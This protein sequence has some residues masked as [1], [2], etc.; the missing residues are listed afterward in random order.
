MTES[1]IGI[2]SACFY[3][4]ET[5]DSVKIC[6]E[7][8]FSNVEIFMNSFS[9]LEKPYLTRL[10]QLCTSNQVK[11]T[12]IHPFTSGYEYMLFFSAYE[13]RAAD[14]CGMYRKYFSAAA[15]LGADFVVFHGD[16]MRAPFIGLERYTEVYAM[17]AE[18]A[19]SEGV[20]LAQENVS[21]AHSGSAEFIASLRKNL[22]DISFVLDIK[23]V[24]RAGQTPEAMIGAMGDRI[25]HIHINDWCFNGGEGRE[26]SC[27]L[28]G[29]GELD[30]GGIVKMIEDT[31]YDGRYMIEVYR[32]NFTELSDITAAFKHIVG[33]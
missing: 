19:K 4:N 24:L 16:S 21:A 22:P 18:T 27:R 14:S 17:L 10:K 33:L 12:S 6:T 20:T 15:E 25:K 26:D 3:P 1:R 29:A 2:S 32:K 23:Q 11:V 31:G 5:I 13:K 8:G 7:L 28:P 9:E 30:L